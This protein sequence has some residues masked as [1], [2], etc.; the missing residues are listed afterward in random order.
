[1]GSSTTLAFS[2]DGVTIDEA[3]VAFRLYTQALRG[4]SEDS[5]MDYEFE[6]EVTFNSILSPYAF[7][8]IILRQLHGQKP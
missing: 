7:G 4:E 3:D 2:G 8:Q 5:E 1:M 6:Q